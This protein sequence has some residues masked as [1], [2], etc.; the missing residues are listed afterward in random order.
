MT[1]T[2][3]DGDRMTFR[4]WLAH[5]LRRVAFRLH[6]PDHM[7]RIVLREDATGRE[8][9]WVHVLCDCCGHGVVSGW[10]IDTPL[11]DTGLTLVW[12]EEADDE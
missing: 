1:Q 4:E 8:L 12:D 11:G 2:P 10:M 5:R 3:S 9:A 6:N 7:C